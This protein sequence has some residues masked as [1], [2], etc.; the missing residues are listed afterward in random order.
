MEGY[1]GMKRMRTPSLIDSSA[2]GG[3]AKKSGQGEP[4]KSKGKGKTKSSYTA[5]AAAR[6]MAGLEEEDEE[7]WMSKTKT[8]MLSTKL[9][10][11]CIQR[12]RE[13]EGAVYRSFLLPQEHPAAKAMLEKGVE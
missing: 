10:L 3:A 9:T 5:A 1:G 12:V 13:L 2:S 7:T 11:N 4:G 6:A 8:T